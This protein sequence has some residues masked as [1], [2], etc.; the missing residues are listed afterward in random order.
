MTINWPT[1]FVVS[2]EKTVILCHAWGQD[3]ALANYV[4]RLD[5]MASLMAIVTG[6]PA[7]S[8]DSL[9]LMR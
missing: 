6:S 8:L 7:W 5:R 2:S 3:C 4:V 9:Y 1:E